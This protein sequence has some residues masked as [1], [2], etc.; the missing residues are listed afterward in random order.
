MHV[1]IRVRLPYTRKLTAEQSIFE[2]RGLGD[3]GTMHSKHWS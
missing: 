1:H 2:T 3:T